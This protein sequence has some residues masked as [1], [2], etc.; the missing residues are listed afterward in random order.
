MLTSQVDDGG[1]CVFAVPN[2]HIDPVWIWGWREGMREVVATFQAAV[3]RLE[4]DGQLR[5]VASSAV[6]YA[7]VAELEP[8][9]FARISSLVRAGRW[10]LVGGQWVEPDCV[11]PAGESVCRQF[12]YSQRFLRERFGR[13]AR[14]GYNVD[15]FGHAATLPQLLTKAG[16]DAYVMM[17]P[18]EHERP[19]PGCLFWWRGVD[20]T[21]IR[22][23][24]IPGSYQTGVADREDPEGAQ[25]RVVH[26]RAG[27]ALKRSEAEGT[28]MMVFVGVGDH[29]G[30][31]TTAAIASL[32]EVAKK[33]GGAV[34]FAT[35]SE[36][37]TA[38]PVSGLPVVEGDLHMR[39]V[40]CYSVVAA[41]KDRNIRCETALVE[42]ELWASLSRMATGTAPGT[43]GQ[44]AEAWKRV[45]FNQFHDSLCGTCSIEAFEA[46][47]DFYGFARS[48]AD[49]VEAK[50]TQALARLTG[51]WIP[52][53]QRADRSSSADL[54]SAGLPVPVVAFN[55]L[56]WP[57]RALLELPHP[58]GR[59]RV[60]DQDVVVQPVGSREATRYEHHGLVAVEL[61]AAG[62]QVLW[63][64]DTPGGRPA[65]PD[66]GSAH[67]SGAGVAG[68]GL[69]VEVGPKQGVLQVRSA[70]GRRW[71]AG[72]VAPVVIDD[73]S[74]T[75]SHEVTVYDAAE[76]YPTL[77]SFARVTEEGPLR[78][79][80][81]LEYRWRQSLILVDVAVIA[82]RGELELVVRADWR[83][84]HQVLKLVVPLLLDDVVVT[85]GLP[86]GAV[87]RQAPAAEEVLA[88]W[89]HIREP[90]G[91]GVVCSTDV[92][93]AYDLTGG[94]LR[95]TVLRS[96]RYA[97]HGRSWSG[98][99]VID[100]PATDQG[101]REVRYRLRLHE[102][103]IEPWAGPRQ[104]AEQRAG[105]P[106]VTETWH[107]GPLGER[108]TGL[109]CQPEHVQVGALK[110]SEEANGWIIRLWE[111]AGRPAAARLDVPALARRWEGTL[112]G[113]EVTTLFIPDDPQGA[114]RE[115][116]I[117]EYET[118]L[119]SRPQGGDRT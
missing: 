29:G 55:P 91:A 48:T 78:A 117:S 49:T 101:W 20:G 102:G 89:L 57:V 86:Y 31:P 70:G 119:A 26:E 81:R 4:A 110:R 111:S 10:E 5:F 100:S 27:E 6:Y 85:A 54:Y 72:K 21:A 95:L 58:A 37:F 41:V 116:L 92:G 43:G 69:A 113:Y 64:D 7:W 18:Q 19:L 59:V 97:D 46:V 51:T 106:T 114:V 87:Q 103:P 22:T 99:D 93:C 36:F 104:A 68:G 77:C 62:L 56:A 9:L 74:D 3:E 83:E 12:L 23:F 45:L 96:P 25:R 47:E 15:S 63:L 98:E 28:P 1:V 16:L 90:S 65:R 2:A 8:E 118:D 79:A 67:V 33:T 38:A 32:R 17:R 60:N 112:R 44:L 108:W 50:A 53:A 34:D 109:V 73:P 88:G 66:P 76:Q 107:P 82:P 52:G 40:G 105:F 61:P 14:V 35:V 24:R 13:T 80:V 94:R 39:A 115:V 75:W 11:L 30:G 42:A 84:R 71:L